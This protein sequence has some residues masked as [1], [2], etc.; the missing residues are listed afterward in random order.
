MS[1][2]PT[3]TIADYLDIKLVDNTGASQKGNYCLV[4]Y[5]FGL[6]EGEYYGWL[7]CKS[8]PKYM[9]MQILYGSS[10]A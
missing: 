4:K 3:Q 9:T 10:P 8:A 5:G 1:Q 6:Y 7:L 2:W